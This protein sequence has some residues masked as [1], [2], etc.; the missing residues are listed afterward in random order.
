MAAALSERT[1]RS[2]ACPAQLARRACLNIHSLHRIR[3]LTPASSHARLVN[4]FTN[5]QFKAYQLKDAIP[6]KSGNYDLGRSTSEPA[7]AEP[8]SV[9]PD[10]KHRAEL[11]LK[12][13]KVS[14]RTGKRH[15]LPNRAACGA[16]GVRLVVAADPSPCPPT[17]DVVSTL[18]F[19]YLESNIK[20]QFVNHVM[21]SAGPEPIP[22]QENAKLGTPLSPATRRPR[23]TFTGLEVDSRDP[24]RSPLTEQERLETKATLQLRKRRAAELEYQ[25]R[26]QAE[27]VGARESSR[28]ARSHARRL[29]Y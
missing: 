26:V 10:D 21:Q 3:K 13:F 20:L 16:V 11:D 28:L 12:A 15:A 6:L 22:K 25:I 14:L 7:G 23:L 2:V 18:K 17:Q 8:Y 9:D 1:N 29:G 4:G 5:H 27:T 19:A 24:P